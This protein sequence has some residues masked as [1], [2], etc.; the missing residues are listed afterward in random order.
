MNIFIAGLSYQINDADL[1]QLFED[2]EQFLQ[3]KLSQTEIQ[4]VQ[5]DSVLLKWMMIQ[6]DNALL[7]N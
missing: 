3:Q 4:A 5:K 1:K 6:K 7:K 2:T